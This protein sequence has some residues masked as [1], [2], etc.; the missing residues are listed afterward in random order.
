MPYE[1]IPLGMEVVFKGILILVHSDIA[2]K[3]IGDL[4]RTMHGGGPMIFGDFACSVFVQ[5]TGAT[6]SHVRLLSTVLS[7]G[8]PASEAEE[9]R[10]RSPSSIGQLSLQI[11]CTMAEAAAQAAAAMRDYKVTIVVH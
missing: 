6:C 1:P 9:A 4:N 3:K 2:S 8:Q 5:A 7:L 11:A 10:Y